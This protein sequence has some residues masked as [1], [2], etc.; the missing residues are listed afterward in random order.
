LSEDAA[1]SARM[2]EYQLFIH[3]EH[4]EWSECGIL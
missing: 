1:S 4:K 3:E 2:G